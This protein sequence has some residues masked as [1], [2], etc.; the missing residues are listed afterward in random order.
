MGAGLGVFQET[1][2]VPGESLVSVT[3]VM[4]PS[5]A[6]VCATAKTPRQ[7]AAAAS[8]TAT[9]SLRTGRELPAPTPIAKH[10]VE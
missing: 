9:I 4:A 3:P 8:R 7:V 5:A 1:V 6:W 10:A 2:R